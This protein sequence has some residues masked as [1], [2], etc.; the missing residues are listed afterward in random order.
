M[1]SIF[2]IGA[3]GLQAAMAQMNVT[4]LD[5]A[6]ANTPGFTAET[7]DLYDI[8]TGGVDS[9]EVENTGQTVDMAAEL[10]QQRQ[11]AMLYDANAM[12]VNVANQ[13]YGTLLNMLDTD[14]D[15]SQNQQT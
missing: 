13:M 12:V 10:T 4:S 11:A 14:N 15:D 8:S 1:S 3:S 5:I 7:V 9:S 2:G 6:N